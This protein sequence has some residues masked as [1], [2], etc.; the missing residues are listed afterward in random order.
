M[1][2]K[3][4]ICL[5]IFLSLIPIT[6]NASDNYAAKIGNDYYSN[7]EDA[8]ANASSTDIITLT[9]NTVLDE[10][11]LI[12]KVINLNLNNRTI[13][14]D[15]KVFLVQGGT[16]NITGPGTIKETKPNYGAIMVLGSDDPSSNQ[17]TTVDIGKD[18]TLEG[19]SGIFINHHNNTAYGIKV[20]FS[21]DINAINDTSGGT[22]IG[23]YVNGKIKNLSNEPI[24]N[25]L[26]G[27]KITSTGN[28]LYIAGNSIFDIGKAY[29]EGDESGIGIKAGTLNINGAT[30]ESN[31]S[32]ETP[33]E[34]YNNGIKASGTA[35]QIESN[36]GYAGNI[37]LNIK[38]GNLKS[39]N[40]YVIYEYIGKGNQ[41]QVSSINI[42]GGL[43]KSNTKDVF[44]VS[45]EFKT[46]HPNFISGGKYSST[47]NVYL[48][49]SY[50]A[51][52]DN[53]LYTVMKSTM[54]EEILN[55]I[56]SND[57]NILKPLIIIIVITVL[58][59]ITYINR[60]KIINLFRR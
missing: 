18:V 36:S 48:K 51:T 59:I 20:D 22:G 42:E 29:I 6:T 26:D 30:I 57:N 55:T 23:I 32:D 43:F 25:I 24:I 19:W 40:S 39:K 31:G 1:F 52:L 15:E 46:K 10:T 44:G 21:G 7:L 12:D 37:K 45:N 8:I 33:T 47:P 4:V 35:L 50:T 27:A 58:V 5:I 49:P 28:G 53:G 2:K 9:T 38:T 3:V 11:L 54:K 13:S 34:G 17:Y 16:L 41:T 14:A 56:T 60:N